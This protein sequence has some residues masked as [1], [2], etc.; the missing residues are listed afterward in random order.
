MFDVQNSSLAIPS[1]LW[2]VNGYFTKIVLTEST[3]N[4]QICAENFIFA[5]PTPNRVGIGINLLKYFC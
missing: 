2:R 4:V 1:P 3:W 5:T